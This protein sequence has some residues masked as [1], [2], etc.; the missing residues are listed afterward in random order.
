MSQTIEK[1]SCECPE[2]DGK[3]GTSYRVRTG[4]ETKICRDK[5]LT[6]DGEGVR[7]CDYCGQMADDLY[8]HGDVLCRACLL[9]DSDVFQCDLC[10][11]FFEGTPLI[12]ILICGACPVETVAAE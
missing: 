1:V 12:E 4:A 11:E 7:G 3:G 5:C 10:E 8:E 9:K 6:C 2:C